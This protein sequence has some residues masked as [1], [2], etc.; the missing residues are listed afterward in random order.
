MV[1]KSTAR[2]AAPTSAPT[3]HRSNT[4][5][6]TGARPR[7]KRELDRDTAV[8]LTLR[9]LHTLYSYSESATRFA[10]RTRGFPPGFKDGRR[11]LWF[12]AD[13]DAYFARLAAEKGGA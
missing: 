9:D 1:T 11:H 10:I 7:L 6:K 8:I 3:A 4:F 13:V 2:K 5:E 12:K